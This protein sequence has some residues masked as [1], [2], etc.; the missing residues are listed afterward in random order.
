MIAVLPTLT[1][2]NH[3]TIATGAYPE[4]TNIPMNT[5][6]DTETAL[7]T[8]TSGFG[9]TI[10]AE[11]LWQAARRQGKKVITIAF[12]GADGRADRKGAA[13]KP[14]D[15]GSVTAFHSSNS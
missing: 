10:N 1:A 2:A 13:I 6:H 9:A 4:R 14:W 15:S 11:T 7:T 12:A 5:F 8:T 3:I